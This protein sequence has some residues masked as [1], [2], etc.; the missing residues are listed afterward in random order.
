LLFCHL[1]SRCR[2]ESAH[3][4]RG[5]PKSSH[6]SHASASSP[7][8]PAAGHCRNPSV[9][10]RK[11]LRRQRCVLCGDNAE[12][13]T[14]VPGLQSP[15]RTTSLALVSNRAILLGKTNPVGHFH[16]SQAACLVFGHRQPFAFGQQPRVDGL[17]L[18]AM[19][20]R[21]AGCRADGRGPF[22]AAE[23]IAGGRNR[24]WEAAQQRLFDHRQAQFGHGRLALRI[25][26]GERHLD[27]LAGPQRRLLVRTGSLDLYRDFQIALDL[28][29]ARRL[30]EPL[31]QSISTLL[32][33]PSLIVAGL[34]LRRLPHVGHNSHGQVEIRRQLG[35]HGNGQLVF[36]VLQPHQ[37]VVQDLGA[38][39]RHEGQGRLFAPVQPQLRG[40]ADLERVLVGQDPQPHVVLVVA[41]PDLDFGLDCV[42]EAI[43]AADPQSVRAALGQLQR[44]ASHAV[45]RRLEFVL[46]DRDFA[47]PAIDLRV[48]Q[49]VDGQRLFDRLALGIGGGDFQLK[50]L[51]GQVNVSDSLSG[52]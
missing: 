40:V 51:A 32:V 33:F 37:L 29:G 2:G 23:E 4:W 1:L 15:G 10:H 19:L 25:G 3:L 21:D 50:R 42:L 52:E 47:L 41:D 48:P 17:R 45:G 13:I 20:E 6:P 38:L 35:G 12:G 16:L 44:L 11:H 36:A 30:V 9:R 24:R 7:E 49:H 31:R 27:F 46:P 39:E 28:E 18:R 34:A 43:D 26:C 14:G 8:R 22:G 5:C